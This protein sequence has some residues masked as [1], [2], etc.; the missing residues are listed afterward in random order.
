MADRSIKVT[1]RANVADFTANMKAAAN[2]ADGLADKLGGTEKVA[3]TRLGRIAQSAQHLSSQMTTVGAAFAA[4]GAGTM[5]GLKKSVDTAIEW[6]SAWTGVTKTVDGTRSEMARLSQDLRDL[7]LNMPSSTTEIASVAEAAGQLGV[8]V[9]DVK[10]FTRTMIDLGQT[11]NLSADEAASTL[12]KFNNIMGLSNK[13]VRSTGNSLVAL[14]NNFATT[15]ADIAQMSLRLASAGKQSG[16]SAKDVMGFATA[17]SSVGVEAEAGG[18]AVSKVF[19]GINDAVIDGGEKLNSF[20]QTAGMTAQEFQQMAKNN[21]ADAIMAWV[22]GIGE[23]SK[24]GQSTTKAFKDVGLTD[25]RLMNAIRSIGTAS[26][27]T[28]AAI[29]TANNASGALATEAEK[30]YSTVESQIGIMKNHISNA[31]IDFGSVFL[32]A[33]ANATEGIAGFADM[34]A[35]LPDPVKGLIGSMGALAGTVSLLG[36]SFLLLAPRILEGVKALQSLGLLSSGMVGKLGSLGGVVGRFAGK[37]ALPATVAIASVG[38]FGALSREVRKPW[39]EKTKDDISD[40]LISGKIDTFSTFGSYM[41]SNVY[42]KLQT[43]GRD[44]GNLESWLNFNA[45]TDAAVI[46]QLDRG[47]ASMVSSGHAEEA[48]RQFKVFSDAALDA[49]ASTEKLNELFPEYTAEAAAV[50][51]SAGKLGDA[52]G[53]SA[54]KA[55]DVAAQWGMTAEDFEKYQDSITNSVLALTDVFANT[56]KEWS[57]F[58]SY[59]AEQRKQIEDMQA[60]NERMLQVLATGNQNVFDQLM[61][62]NSKSPQAA[63]QLLSSMFDETGN[64]VESKLNELSDTISQNRSVSEALSS[65]I[66]SKDSISLLQ[67]AFSTLKGQALEDFKSELAAGEDL[68]ELMIKYH[69]GVDTSEA[70]A[71]MGDFESQNRQ[72]EIKVDA[73]PEEALAKIAQAAEQGN[74]TISIID[75]D[76]NPV[77]A[78]TKLGDLV[79]NINSK[80]GTVTIAGNDYPATMTVE[81][82]I[83]QHREA[84]IDLVVRN[85][86]VAAQLAEITGR[87]YSAYVNI[88]PR[89]NQELLGK[90][91]TPRNSHGH[92]VMATGGPVL[93]PGT[94]TSDS[95][96]AWL[97]NGEYVVKAAAVKRYGFEFLNQINSMK[98]AS[99]GFVG[100]EGPQPGYKQMVEPPT[101]TVINLKENHY[102]PAP[103]S[104]AIARGKASQKAALVAG[105][106]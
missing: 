3:G 92:Q 23:M 41:G 94:G 70:E 54:D 17:L 78:E 81:E 74:N 43:V 69:V 34:L 89:V 29:N 93:G 101:R 47:F 7:S 30:R 67:K 77:P 39:I 22:K 63:A 35:S 56:G 95:I 105:G 33:I 10:E 76:G 28:A 25:Q 82:F 66:A 75:I 57:G 59:I 26:E 45:D 11:T 37:A 44:A 49:G 96:P 19:I 102:Y 106:Y 84:G 97:S 52:M 12:A 98:L 51:E 13:S 21:P 4:F 72:V 65:V 20:A 8:K 71:T 5:Y 85:N 18:T 99:G 64:L 103:A 87:S 60:F 79:G 27:V 6:E 46:S 15:E 50:T 2:S 58:D 104:P 14:G 40:Q 42:E 1:L 100:K 83:N 32:P 9:G 86:L 38:V 88:N 62:M 48:A 90:A 16:L 61:A 80:T 73:N 68:G 24:A 31:A 36:G 91:L 55:I 53:V